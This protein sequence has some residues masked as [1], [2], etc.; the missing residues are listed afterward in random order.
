MS[1][2]EKLADRIRAVLAKQDKD[3]VERKMFGGICFM[4]AGAMCCGVLNDDLIVKIERE[5]N[6]EALAQPHA[7]PF[8]FSGRPMAGI[9]YVAPKG[10]ATAAQ[11]KKW[12]DRGLAYV[13]TDPKKAKKKA[14][15][16]RKKARPRAR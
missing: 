2:D 16:S 10:V 14:V 5:K 4:V 8:D 13:A 1:Y 6:D 3:V 15:A 9:L 12:I 11:L 7:R